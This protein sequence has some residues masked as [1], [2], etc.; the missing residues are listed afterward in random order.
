MAPELALDMFQV[1]SHKFRGDD[2]GDVQRDAPYN[3]TIR[4]LQS[5][6]YSEHMGAMGVMNPGLFAFLRSF[7][8]NGAYIRAARRGA[9]DAR[10][11]MRSFVLN[12]MI[13][14]LVRLFDQRIF[15]FS[16]VVLSLMALRCR[17]PKMF[18]G[19]L[20]AN[21]IL[22]SYDTALMFATDMGNLVMH[23]PPPEDASKYVMLA[24]YDNCQYKLG[25]NYEHAVE[26]RRNDRYDCCNWFTMYLPNTMD[27]EIR[28]CLSEKKGWNN[29]EAPIRVRTALTNFDDFGRLLGDVWSFCVDVLLEDGEF[30]LLYH[31]DVDG[32]QDRIIIQH[33]VPT[34][35]G[36]AAYEDNKIL[37]A[38]IGAHVKNVLG[39]QFAFVVGDQQSY[40][41]M[42]FLKRR[43]TASL[44][45]VIPMPGDFHFAVHY[46]MGI[47]GL[48]FDTFISWFVLTIGLCAKTCG[49]GENP[50]KWGSVEKYNDYRF[51]YEVIIVSLMRYLKEAVPP[52]L[53]KNIPLLMKLA[54][55][56]RGA[57][58]VLHFL[59]GFALPWLS[60]RQSIR[61]RASRRVDAF[62]EQSLPM[63]LASKKKL[64][65]QLV[66]DH[67]YVTMS[68]H[69]SFKRLW[70][71]HRTCSQRGNRG[72]DVGWD[73]AMEQVNNLLKNGISDGAKRT[74][75]DV[76]ITWQ[77]GIR[78][79]EEKLKACL[80]VPIQDL[81]ERS[82]V[83]EADV[84][85]VVAELKKALPPDAFLSELA[86]SPFG[87][88]EP[89]KVVA[90]Q[91]PLVAEYVT[92][93]INKPDFEL[94]PP[95]DW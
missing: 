42:T 11:I 79:I 38:K 13:G 91:R 14:W 78:D 35:H 15:V 64:Y 30:A 33:H 20:S 40:S 83:E 5:E 54:E 17:V 39:R 72:R 45:F 32:A 12:F 59:F 75:I 80:G 26:Q 37:L 19:V 29:R 93:H 56:N 47:H 69:D 36:T 34:E 81:D 58:V 88:G 21:R 49:G 85:F 1:Q 60:L 68:L 63:F 66:V 9:A 95:A 52:G 84:A 50:A 76:F 67:T 2:G 6:D 23:A 89:W 74:S 86:V 16:H 18:W 24:V 71:L 82:A 62:W 31:P 51:L 7:T 28:E 53:L 55:Q 94:V 43:E 87:S 73:Q 46:L 10:N 48:W 25:T 57:T 90:S 61:A 92:K 41:R 77:N 4:R 44:E 8:L 65:S 70:Y 27:P 22:Y 3:E